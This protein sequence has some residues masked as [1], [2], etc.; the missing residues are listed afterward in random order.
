MISKLN[1]HSNE[2]RAF[3]QKNFQFKQT[4]KILLFC[5]LLKFNISLAQEMASDFFAY[6]Y[7]QIIFESNQFAWEKNTSFGPLRYNDFDFMI[8]NKISEDS[9]KLNRAIGL[10]VDFHDYNLYAFQRISYKS[11]FYTYFYFRL[12]NDDNYH[13][14]Y[15]GISRKK[16]R[17]GLSS[18]EMDFAGMGYEDDN[19]LLQFGR[20]RQSWGVGGDIKIGLSEYSPSYD[21]GLLGLKFGKYKF[22]YFNGFLE[23]IDSYNRYITGRS[24][25]WNNNKNI[26]VSFSEIVIYS[27]LNRSLDFAY[28]NPVSTHLEIELNNRQNT[29]GV[30]S[31]NAVWQFSVDYKFH[32]D[33]RIMTNF[34]IDEFVLDKIQLDSNK[35]NGLALSNK[36]I[37]NPPYIPENSNIFFSFIAAGTKTFRHEMGYNNFVHRGHPLGWVYGSDGYEIASG[38]N[39]FLDRQF[40]FISKLGKRI[41]GSNSTK[42]LPYLQNDDYLIDIYPSNPVKDI[43]FID[44]KFDLL[45]KHNLHLHTH[46]EYLHNIIEDPEIKLN[47]GLN[48][49]VNK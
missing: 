49:S 24:L 41:I 45:L 47:F 13:S 6:R 3:R 5:L 18:G 21:Y 46:V 9:L 35:T 44:L 20:G 48:I 34:I 25:E 1:Y 15:T 16:S 37:W 43:F 2:N 11:K 10:N 22:R 30:I 40:L 28:L 39:L 33:L 31:G 14:R 36:I 23:N 8:K 38:F 32:R 7:N 19:F 29:L 42:N 12:V 26:L 4:M 17:L 27:G